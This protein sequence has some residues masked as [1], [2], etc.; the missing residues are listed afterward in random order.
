MISKTRRTKFPTVLIASLMSVAATP[1]LMPSLCYAQQE[2]VADQKLKTAM[3]LLKAKSQ[4]LGPPRIEGKSA[5]T[6]QNI[7]TI[8]FGE[9]KMND[10]FALVDEVQ[11]EAGGIA[12]IFVKNGDQFIRVATNFRKDV[13]TRA[14]GTPLDPNGKV[15]AAI[16]SNQSFY[17]EADI[18]GKPYVTAYEPIRGQDGDVIGIYFVGYPK[19]LL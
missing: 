12:T 13:G 6:T 18:L 9:T 14:T 10:N 7:P 17:G 11:K 1:M 2:A 19:G 4:K 8:Y 16:R 15:I 5:A 3:E